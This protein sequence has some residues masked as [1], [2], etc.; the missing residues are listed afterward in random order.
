MQLTPSFK[1]GALK[2]RPLSKLVTMR[3]PTRLSSL[4]RLLLQ[5]SF[6]V[7]K[8]SPPQERSA[9]SEWFHLK[10]TEGPRLVVCR[11][12]QSRDYR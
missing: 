3:L 2:V 5:V 6:E 1:M 10:Q 8:I 7:A 12:L 4:S 9:R 11:H